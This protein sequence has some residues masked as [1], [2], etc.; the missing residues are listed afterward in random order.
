M[1]L[2]S[3]STP[4]VPSGK[5]RFRIK[6]KDFDGNNEQGAQG[7]Y[8]DEVQLRRLSQEEIEQM[9]ETFAE[10][11]QETDKTWARRLVENVLQKNKWY[12]PRKDV[13][14]A[15]SLS[16]AWAFYEHM[17]L[18]R[19]VWGTADHVF[20]LA[21]PGETTT[22]TALLQPLKMPGSCFVTFGTGIDQYFETCAILCILC[23]VC[24]IINL[25]TM[26]YYAGPTYSG[27]GGK[28]HLPWLLQASA[29]CTKKVWVVCKDCTEEEWSWA[30]EAGTFARAPDGTALVERNDCGGARMMEGLL[31][32]LTFAFLA[33]FLSLSSYYLYIREA[34]MDEGVQTADDYT[35]QVSNPPS[36]AYDPDEWKEFFE[37]FTAQAQVTLATVA[38]DNEDLL[39]KLVQ[40]R[41]QVENLRKLLPNEVNLDDEIMVRA[42]LAK[43]VEKRNGT[44]RS[45]FGKLFESFLRS[46]QLLIPAETIVNAIAS[47]DEEIKELQTRQYNVSRVLITFET[48]EGKDQAYASL[49]PNTF[50]TLKVTPKGVPTNRYFKGIELQIDQPA[51]PSSVRWLDLSASRIRA[52]FAMSVNLLITLF[53][54]GVAAYLENTTRRLFGPELAGPLVAIFNSII[55]VVVE[56]LM[57]FERHHTEGSW[58]TSFYMK[59][60][61][62]RWINTAIITKVGSALTANLDDASTDVLPSMYAILLSELIIVPL[63]RI[64]DIVGNFK[65]HILAPRAMTQEEMNLNF[66]GTPYRIGE[67]FTALTNVLFVCCFYSALFPSVFVFGFAILVVQYY[68]DKFC[69]VRIWRRA[70]FI[71]SNLA[72]I[73]RRYFF[74]IALVVFISSSAYAW[75]QFPYNNLCDRDTGAAHTSTQEFNNAVLLNGTVA[76]ITV[77]EEAVY[78]C[79]Q[80]V[81]EFD[82]VFPFPPSPRIQPDGY[83]WMTQEQEQIST[84]FGWASLAAVVAF[85]AYFMA[86]IQAF[87][88]FRFSAAR[89]SPG[90]GV[91]ASISAPIETSLLTFRSSPFTPFHIHYWHVMWTVLTR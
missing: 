27:Q 87:F 20:R 60:T 69:L 84:V 75:A 12:F 89:M 82:T 43:L 6:G 58:Q 31:D 40:R 78:F 54:I 36:D 13:K 47:L 65:R 41:G 35:L 32:F 18:P 48:E 76:N 80:D 38:L 83:R 1:S 8:G 5:Q 72:R 21:E 26:M 85:L 70:P 56:V 46:T 62:F 11:D 50:R 9:A 30:E 61:L 52:V 44:D 4:L 23:F 79:S 15:P 3:E 77:G 33:I 19:Y 51:D 68:T 22:K 28:S 71:G 34:R 37:Q 57:L 29:I 42:A 91:K 67:R 73:S 24:A 10:D 25:P 59:I 88:L 81:Q 7:I 53:V 45:C 64:I 74:N 86:E 55:P 39:K 17:T 66:L 16:Q 2:A 63:M 49:S 14:G 90:P